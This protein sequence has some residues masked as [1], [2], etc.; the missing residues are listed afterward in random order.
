MQIKIDQSM[1]SPVK[2][3]SDF[4]RSVRAKGRYSFT[5]EEMTDSIPKSIRNIRK[6]LDR[7]KGKG[8]IVNI[9]R[10]FYTILPPEYHRM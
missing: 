5:M 4:L 3:T 10:G 6:D 7:L 2:H 9:R 1:E 8:E